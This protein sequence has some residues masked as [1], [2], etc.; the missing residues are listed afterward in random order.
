[1][2]RGAIARRGARRCG[3]EG[4]EVT[5]A[6][7]EAG[8]TYAGKHGYPCTADISYAIMRAAD[9]DALLVPGGFAP[10]KMRRRLEVLDLVSNSR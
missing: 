9:F 3:E 2:A 6:G 7:P 5:I 4:W 1:M 8:K 10:D